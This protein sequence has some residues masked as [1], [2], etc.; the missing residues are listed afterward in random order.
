MGSL[1]AS[2]AP[3]RHHFIELYQMIT[4]A[5]AGA[6][7]RTPIYIQANQ[8]NRLKAGLIDRDGQ[9]RWRQVAMSV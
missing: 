3:Y 5:E 4:T 2:A 1:S 9:R 8:E 7:D 6:H